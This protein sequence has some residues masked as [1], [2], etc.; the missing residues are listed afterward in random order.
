[1]DNRRRELEF[2]MG[3]YV[4]HKV[5]PAKG[6][7]RFGKKGKLSPRYVGPFE[8]IGGVSDGNTYALRLPP[9]LA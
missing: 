8:I 3:D 9:Q 4:F 1:M 6:V 7:M 5:S 2:T